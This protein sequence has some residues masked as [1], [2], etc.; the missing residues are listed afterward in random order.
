MTISRSILFAID[1]TALYN[2]PC[3]GKITQAELERFDLDAEKRLLY[4][5]THIL[6]E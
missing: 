3:K 1:N 4:Y 6:R 5:N 2:I